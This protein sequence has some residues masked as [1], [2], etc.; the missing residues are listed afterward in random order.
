MQPALPSNKEFFPRRLAVLLLAVTLL[1]CRLA[2]R[3]ARPEATVQPDGPAGTQPASSPTPGDNYVYTQ[4][5]DGPT[6]SGW[7]MQAVNDEHA[8]VQRDLF[9]GAYRWRMFAM[10][11]V[12]SWAYPDLSVTPPSPDFYYAVTVHLGDAPADLAYGPLF[13]VRDGGNLYYFKVSQLGQFALYL[14]ANNAFTALIA[15][16]AT[17]ALDTGPQATN[18]LAVERSGGLARLYANDQR[19]AEVPLPAAGGGIGLAAELFSGQ[20]ATLSFDDVVLCR[21]ACR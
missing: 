7:P 17:T 2:E 3:A 16:T 21:S 1:S 8:Q 4:N 10:Q 9:A 14:R 15:E 11:D 19:L 18:R 5:F 13:D 6:L 20:S 12:F